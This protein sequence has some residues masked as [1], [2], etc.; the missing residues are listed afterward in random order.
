MRIEYDPTKRNKT[1]RDRGLDMADAG[2]MFDGP[3]MTIEDD[4]R[5]YG[6]TRYIPVGFLV[7]RMMFVAMLADH[8]FE[9][10]QHP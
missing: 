7:G 8:R 6:E 1:L 5:E 4:R 10:G 9:K 2:A 3:T